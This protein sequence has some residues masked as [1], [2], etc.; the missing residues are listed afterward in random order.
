[1]EF[2]YR[3]SYRGAL[4]A[5]VLDWAGTTVDY[6][7][8]APT[9]VFLRLF[10]TRGVHISAE[11]ARSGMGLMKKD[12][13]RTILARPAV[14]A[15]W[16][17]AHGAP[18][19]DA[20]VEALFA[21]F[22]PLQLAVLKEY[23]QPIPGTL[24]TASALHARG[25]KIGSTTGYI[26]SMMEV[27]APLAEECGYAPDAIVCPD[28]VPAGRPYPWMCYQNAI[29][30]GVY[31]LEAMVKVGDTLPDIEEGL[32]AGMWTVGISLTGN[33]LGMSEAEAGS[34]TGE[35]RD[36]YRKDISARLF[37]A[38]AHYVI[39]GIGDLLPAI[40]AIQE[41]LAHGEHP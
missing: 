15:A 11:D 14:A 38:G 13:L 16:E 41:R 33:L 19:T 23:A 35:K 4:K 6:G 17:A 27:L 24:Q 40:D 8:F 37:L 28:D 25:M 3:R 29:C 1:M 2:F 7:S 26:R 10:E 36:A 5:V 39:D 18:T 9:A 31:P 12:H 30:L 32:N 34:L 21:D 20:D 22:V